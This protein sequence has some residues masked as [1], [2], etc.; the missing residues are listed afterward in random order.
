MQARYRTIFV[1]HQTIDDG[2]S[3]PDLEPYFTAPYAVKAIDYTGSGPVIA[4]RTYFQATP[5]A[6]HFTPLSVEFAVFCVESKS[7][8]LVDTYM[9]DGAIAF[10]TLQY[11]QALHSCVPC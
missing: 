1:T 2:I 5:S 8:R 9:D 11:V 3:V 10:V 6:T 7:C 4:W